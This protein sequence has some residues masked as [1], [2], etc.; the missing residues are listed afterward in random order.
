MRFLETAGE[1]RV[2]RIGQEYTDV[3]VGVLV[4]VTDRHG[5][6]EQDRRIRKHRRQQ[7]VRLDAIAHLFGQTHFG[8]LSQMITGAIEG[9]VFGAGVVG[10]LTLV[11]RLR[12]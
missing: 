4:P 6:R 8:L 11:R 9:L 2:L 10:A 1:R 3:Q 5:S 7:R 12:R